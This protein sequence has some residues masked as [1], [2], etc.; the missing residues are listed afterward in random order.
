MTQDQFLDRSKD[1]TRRLGFKNLKRGESLMGCEK[2]QGLR[3][4]DKI[5]K[6]GA[7]VVVSVTFEPLQRM[8][9]EPLYGRVEAE[10]EG[11][12]EL[13]GGQF[14]E[15]FCSKMNCEPSTVVT[16]I[17]F[18]HVPAV[19]VENKSAFTLLPPAKHLC[20][21]CA[22]EHEPEAPHNL[23]TLYYGVH[24][25]LKHGRSPTWSDALAH[26]SDE[27]RTYW[28]VELK[29]KGISFPDADQIAAKKTREAVA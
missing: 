20:Q 23:Q 21:E 10:R 9:D 25:Y 15:M 12:P 2:C 18:K 8:I 19:S 14:V 24:F 22:F 13:T 27:I 1:V 26:C 4:G 16:R 28:I 29:K 3:K 6:L 11:F 17:E 7:I 5:S